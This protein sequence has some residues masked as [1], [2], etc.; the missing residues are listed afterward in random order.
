MTTSTSTTGVT[1]CGLMFR[2][3]KSPF[4]GRGAVKRLEMKE[5]D[6][7]TKE[8]WLVSNGERVVQSKNRIIEAADFSEQQ[9][10]E[11]F[12]RTKIPY[13]EHNVTPAE[14]MNLA[15]LGRLEIELEDV[16]SEYAIGHIE[17]E[18]TQILDAETGL[19]LVRFPLNLVEY[20]DYIPPQ[21]RRER[22]YP[23]VQEGVDEKKLDGDELVAYVRE[24][25][26][27]AVFEH[28][29]PR[30][31]KEWVRKREADAEKAAKEAS[32]ELPTAQQKTIEAK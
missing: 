11:S 32:G 5:P 18:W 10:T 17:Q 2:G 26:G 7:Y 13:A 12:A 28:D 21:V 27:D 16:S 9:R 29:V 19:P 8:F 30:A 6:D 22:V 20:P 14:Y 25:A 23:F 15:G 24:R 3:V 4:F 31:I 1:K